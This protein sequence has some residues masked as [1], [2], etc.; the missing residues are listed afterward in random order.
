MGLHFKWPLGARMLAALYAMSMVLKMLP[1]LGM[2]CPPKCRCEKLLFYCDSQGFHS[3]PNTTEKGSLGLSLRHNFITELERDQFAS[4]SQL[5]WLHLD[6][7]QIATVR[8]DSFQGLYKLK[9]LVLSSNK[10]FH[11]PNTTFSQLLNLQN[12]DLS[13]NQLSSLHPELLYGLRKLQ[14]LHLRSNSLRTI[15]VRLF[16]DCRSLEFLDLSTNRLRSL[17]RNGFAGL[18]KLRELHLEHNQLTKINFAHFLRLSSL[19]T[20]FLQWN[21]IS[22]LTCGMEWTWG[23]LE[24]LDLTGNE[25]KA[26]DLTVFETMPNL[27]T[28]LM[29]NNKLT[30]LDSKILGSLPSL[31]TVG[32]SGNLWECSPK[33]C[34]LAT[35]LSGFRGRWEHPIL[36]HSPDHTQGEDILDAVHGFQLCWNLSAGATSAAPT[37]AVPTTEYTK[38]ISSSNFHMG[39]KEIPTTAGMVV[40]TEEPFP[41]PNNAIF[42]QRVITGTMALLFSFFFIIFI[43]FISRKCCPPTLRRIRQCSMIQNHRQLRSQTRLHMANMSD[44]GPYNEYEPTHEG[45]FIIINGYGQCKC[46]QLPYK[47]C[48]V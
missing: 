32:L 41:E 31:T 26:I 18:I 29:D 1:A 23:T 14:T 16:W 20:L 11:L 24:K 30:T 42:T 3:V 28:L 43:V 40:T 22:N 37:S 4:F 33:I 38:R 5:T 13:F 21:K 36:C 39:D 6:H 27:K 45:P 15:P 47:E 8:E 48:E 44:Q 19:H 46:Q 12:L 9:E 35:W 10:I 25:I 34:A 7:N 17:A 2:A